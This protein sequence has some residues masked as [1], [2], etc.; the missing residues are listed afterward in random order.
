MKTLNT[1]IP[2]QLYNQVT[3]LVKD[4]W[5][6]NENEVIFV[7]IHRFIDSHSG[8]LMEKYIRDDVEWGLHGSE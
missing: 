8:A 3:T 5:F 6:P 2:D 4:G 1:Q 7:A